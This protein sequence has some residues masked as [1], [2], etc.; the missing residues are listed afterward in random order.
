MSHLP[1]P[2]SLDPPADSVW[3]DP[4][5]FLFTVFLWASAMCGTWQGCEAKRDRQRV[6]QQLRE[7]KALIEA[8]R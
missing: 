5:R 6:E 3:G 8:K 2:A 1:P 7:I 4:T